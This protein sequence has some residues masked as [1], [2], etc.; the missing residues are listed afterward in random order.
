MKKNKHKWQVKSLGEVCDVVRGSSPRPK[1]DKRFYDGDVP[2]LMVA[3]LTRD[4]MYVTPRID[5]LTKEG[6]RQSREMKAG[7][8]VIAVSG[9]P[10]LTAILNID[11]YIHDG[12]VGLRK[13]DKAIIHNEYLYHYLTLLKRENKSQAVGAIFKNLR[14]DQIKDWCIPLPPLPIQKQIAEILEQADKSKQKRQQ[15]NKLTDEFLQSVFIEKFGDP[16][17]NPKGWEKKKIE[18]LI[19]KIENENPQKF[20]MKEYDYI[21]ISSIDNSRKIIVEIKKIRGSSAP[22]RA[23]Q[24]V[25]CND[26]LVSTVRPNLNAVALVKENFSNPIASTGFCILRS[27]SKI[28]IPEFLFKITNQSFFVERLFKLAKGASY[29]A[30]TD[31]QITG[32]EIP[33]PPLPVQK[34]IAEI[35]NKTESLK[36]KQKQSE[37]ELENLFQ[38]L[39]QRAFRGKLL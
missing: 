1:S 29:P 30:V 36:E 37:Q 18:D 28:V 11:A 12:F 15:A 23:R 9:N 22:S 24:L 34:Q 35:V 26:I 21:D 10:G 3:D 13:L 4:G 16:V 38:S 32:I 7:D 19:L 25:K 20:P 5:F 39:M 6:S 8:I 14:T 2:R 33:I 31:G 17:K 27:N